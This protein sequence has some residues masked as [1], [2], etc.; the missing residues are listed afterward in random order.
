MMTE[1]FLRPRLVG[2]RFEGRSIPLEVLKDLAVLEEMIVEVAKSEFLRDHPSRRRSPRG[3]TEGIELKLTGIEEGSTVP[4]ISLVIAATSLFYAPLFSLEEKPPEKQVYF[5]RARDAVVNAIGA[6]EQNQSITEYLPEKTL[7]YFDRLGRS[8]RDG[9]AIEFSTLARQTPARLTRETRRRLILAS[10]R[11]KELTEE[12]IVRGA[13]PEADQDD[14][15]F[16]LQLFDG[17]KIKA[18]MTAQHLDTVLEAFNAFK[19]GIRV[20]MQGIGRFN[21]TEKLVGFESVEHISVLD[22]LDVPARLEE[23]RILREGWFEGIGS[24]PTAAGIDWLSDKFAQAYPEDLPLPFVYPTPEGG[25][26]LEWSLEPHDITLDIDLAK[27][28]ARLHELNLISD[29]DQE[30]TLNLDEPAEWARLVE[31]IQKFVGGSS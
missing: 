15:T 5:E 7:G 6:A 25:I 26:R 8:L 16:E 11:V 1:P 24:A 20:L 30:K 22:P 13:V 21:R 23:L 18:P 2:A 17:R 14:M 27:H 12:T 4:V 31:Q 29:E 10:S 9:E 19:A 3:F 28:T